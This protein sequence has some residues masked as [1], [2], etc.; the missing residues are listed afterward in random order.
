MLLKQD[1]CD[2]AQRQL[3]LAVDNLQIILERSC[4]TECELYRARLCGM[5]TALHSASHSLASAIDN[6]NEEGKRRALFSVTIQNAAI[7]AA[8]LTNKYHAV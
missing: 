3:N 4:E 5:G 8:G 6:R 1:H 2:E 7:A